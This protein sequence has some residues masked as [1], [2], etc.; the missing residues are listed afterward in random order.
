MEGN[1]KCGFFTL[2]NK[3]KSS[4]LVFDEVIFFNK[5]T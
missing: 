1:K 3:G 2:E 5:C 4:A